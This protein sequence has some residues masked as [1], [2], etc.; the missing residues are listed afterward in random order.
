[1]IPGQ[2]NLEIVVPI[3]PGQLGSIAKSIHRLLDRHL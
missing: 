2:W 1:M 3:E